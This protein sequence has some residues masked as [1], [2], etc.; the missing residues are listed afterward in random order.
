MQRPVKKDLFTRSKGRPAIWLC[1][2]DASLN[3]NRRAYKYYWQVCTL[4]S[5]WEDSEFFKN[6]PKLSIAAYVKLEKRLRDEGKS[7]F[8]YN[9]KRLRE[10]HGLP[11]DMSHPRW[12]GAQLAPSLEDDTDPEHDGWK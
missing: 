1:S 5:E 3:P 8:V 2:G 11:L 10:G 4:E 9:S 6:A 12:K 7:A